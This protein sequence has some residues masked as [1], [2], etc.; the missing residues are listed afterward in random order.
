MILRSKDANKDQSYFLWQIKKEQLGKILFPVGEFENK[1]QVREYAKENG[2]ITASKPDSQG[3]CFI[4][5]TP[6]REM[7]LQT[8]GEKIGNILDQTGKILGQHKGAYL[9]TIGQRQGLG[10]SGGPWYVANVD[11]EN[12]TVTVSTNLA[13][14]QGLGLI[15]KNPNWHQDLPE[16]F[17]CKCQ[18]RYQQKPVNCTVKQ[19]EN[20][21]LEVKFA[22][23]T[24]A[25]AKGQSIVFYLE[26]QLLGGAIIDCLI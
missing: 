20:N 9:Y 12:N 7:L 8:L 10:L 2:L 18:I 22:D 16:I 5:Q 3:L 17:E 4:G 24:N 15:A 26:N 21:T 13:N 23:P 25:I 1:T 19:L 6:L 14:L 11:V